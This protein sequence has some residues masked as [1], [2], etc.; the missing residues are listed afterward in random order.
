MGAQTSKPINK[1]G[2][3]ND[4]VTLRPRPHAAHLSHHSLPLTACSAAAAAHTP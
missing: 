3:V 4:I 2:L 1:I